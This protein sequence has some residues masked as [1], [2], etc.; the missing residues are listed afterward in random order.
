MRP[1]NLNGVVVGSKNK[2]LDSVKGCA[3]DVGV[4]SDSGRPV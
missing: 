2:K 1:V 3:V 4:L